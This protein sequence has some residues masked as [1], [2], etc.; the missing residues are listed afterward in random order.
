MLWCQQQQHPYW[1]T[2]VKNVE[3]SVCQLTDWVTSIKFGMWFD[4]MFIIKKGQML[5]LLF[6]LNFCQSLYHCFSLLISSVNCA[7]VWSYLNWAAW[8]SQQTITTSEMCTNWPKAILQS[9]FFCHHHWRRI[10]GLMAPKVSNECFWFFYH[11]LV[12]EVNHRK[13]LNKMNWWSNW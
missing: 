2:T 7:T 9:S 5:K 1:L 6:R 3:C 13:D 4:A 12:N 8:L 10:N 11:I